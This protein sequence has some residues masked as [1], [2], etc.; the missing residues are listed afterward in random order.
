[1]IFN[2]DDDDGE[3]D[4]SDDDDH[5]ENNDC[6]RD[7]ID[8]SDSGVSSSTD[9]NTLLYYCFDLS[10]FCKIWKKE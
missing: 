10:L 3:N 1:M 2:D 6:G 4:K 7:G 9:K 5:A 8:D